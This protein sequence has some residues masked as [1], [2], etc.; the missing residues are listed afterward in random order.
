MAEFEMTEYGPAYITVRHWREDHRY[1]FLVERRDGKRVLGEMS[2]MQGGRAVKNAR[3]YSLDARAFA[4]HTA[5]V[6]GLID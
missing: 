6:A 5:S 1:S 4:A 3:L 2:M